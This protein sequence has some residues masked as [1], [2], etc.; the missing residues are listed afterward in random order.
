MGH[1]VIV[2]CQ[3]RWKSLSSK[4]GML[5]FHIALNW[6][7]ILLAFYLIF[8][9]ILTILCG[10][11]LRSTHCYTIDSLNKHFGLRSGLEVI[12]L[13]SCSTQMSMKCFLLIKTK[14]LTNIKKFFALNLSD[15][16]FILL[17]NVKMPTISCSAELST[18]MKKGL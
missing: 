1:L 3:A 10:K 13:F 16:V 9:I 6:A 11:E 14:I 7:T 17:I 5:K 8:D 15:G 4:K 2:I 18:C 12:K